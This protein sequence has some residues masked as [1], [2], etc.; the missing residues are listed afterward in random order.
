MRAID[1][2]RIMEPERRED[3]RLLIL[4]ARPDVFMQSSFC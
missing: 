4:R 1:P 2:L 3:E